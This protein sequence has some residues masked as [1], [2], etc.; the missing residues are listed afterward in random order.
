LTFIQR[1]T[2][3]AEGYVCSQMRLITGWSLAVPRV[4]LNHSSS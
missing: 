4:A 1:H 2:K 3:G